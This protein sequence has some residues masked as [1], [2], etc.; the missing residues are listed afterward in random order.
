M[1]SETRIGHVYLFGKR[2]GLYKIGFSVNPEQRLRAMPDGGKGLRVV[3]T[4]PSANARSLEKRMHEVYGV[5]R[6]HGEWFS[7]SKSDVSKWPDTESE[8]F[9]MDPLADACLPF[10]VQMPGWLS[11]F[12]EAKYGIT[13]RLDPDSTA[14]LREYIDSLEVPVK[15]TV[16]LRTAL[17][18]FLRE[19]GFLPPLPQKP[20]T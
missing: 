7:L 3:A 6:V 1:T 9:Q 16:V 20:K 10:P 4:I 18:A 15:P 12:H 17:R 19:R 11:K 5:R 2:D 8:A 13:L 14:A